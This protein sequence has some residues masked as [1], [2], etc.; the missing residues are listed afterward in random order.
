MGD[1]ATALAPQLFA[2]ADRGGQLAVE[3]RGN[4]Q[5]GAD[6]CVE[7]SGAGAGEGPPERRLE[8]DPTPYRISS[9]AP[10]VGVLLSCDVSF[11]AGSGTE[12][13]LLLFQREGS[14]FKQVLNAT[15]ERDLTDRAGGLATSEASTLSIQPSAHGG[16]FDL[17]LHTTRERGPLG[18][19]SKKEQ[20][21][22]VTFEWNGSAYAPR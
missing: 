3:A 12:R 4:A 2:L 9:G 14:A 22:D 20:A 8:L 11:P 15:T 7:N 19:T 1:T 21:K 13:H 5:L 10:A 16:Y 17:K 6:L 18:G